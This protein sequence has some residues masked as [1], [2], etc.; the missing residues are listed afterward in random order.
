M[1]AKENL[2]MIKEMGTNSYETARAFGELNLRTWEKLAEKQLATF[3][4]FVEAGMAQMKL[5]TETK[6]AKELVNAQAE[7]TKK[8]GEDL[9]AKGRE[10]MA[11]ANE[12]RDEYTALVEKNVSE[13][14]AKVNEVA[15]KAA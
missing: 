7:L 15:Q 2:E 9:V 11:M 4:L 1:N 5:V 13:V 10:A 8:L 6:D 12:V 14:T 3:N